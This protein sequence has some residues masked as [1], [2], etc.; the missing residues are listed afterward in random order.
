VS[1]YA[2]CQWT[3]TVGVAV[4]EV[5][6]ASF[7]KYIL[8]TVK[9]GKFV[10]LQTLATHKGSNFLVPFIVKLS[11]TCSYVVSSTLQPGP[12]YAL[13]R[14]LCVCV[15]VCVCVCTRDDFDVL[16]KKIFVL[17]GYQTPDNPAR[18][19]VS[20]LTELSRLVP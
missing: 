12:R 3:Y 8:R 5:L 1:N 10:P 13:T 9:F 17:A 4:V 7:I 2:F 19:L 20:T 18:S 14:H 16:E 11:T 6:E 15:C